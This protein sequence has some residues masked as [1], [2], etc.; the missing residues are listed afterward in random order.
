MRPSSFSFANFSRLHLTAIGLLLAAT[1]ARAAITFPV[2][3]QDPG[4]ANS[5]Y[6]DLITSHIQAAGAEWG[7]YL[8]GAGSL[9][10]QVEFTTS[11]ARVDGA[12]FTSGFSHKNGSRDVFEQGATAE[13]RTGADPNGSSPD[14]RFRINPN[15]MRSDMWFDPEP[16]VRSAAIPANKIDAM[17]LF[18][19][20]LGHSFLFTG[21]MDGTT[22][23]LPATYMSTFDEN[24]QFD[25]ANFFFVGANAEAR[26][27]GPVPVT[28][29]NYGHIGNNSPR[30]GSDLLPDL[31]NGV[32]YYYQTRYRISALDFAMLKDA[33]V[34]LLPTSKL[35]NI[36]TRLPVRSGDNALIGG[37][38][39]SGTEPKKIIVRAIGPSLGEAGV[40]GALPDPVLELYDSSGQLIAS[41]D[42]WRSDQESEIQASTIPPANDLESAIVVTLPADN[43]A[44]TA[45]VRGHGEENGIGLIEVY[46]LATGTNSQLANISSRGSVETGENVM[47]GGFIVGDAGGATVIVRGIGPSLA[48]VPNALSDPQLEVRDVNGSLLA[49][50]DNW[51]ET[52]RSQLEASGIAPGNDLESAAI[53]TIGA[54]SYTAVISGKDNKTGIAVVEVYNVQ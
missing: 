47:I 38:I 26:Y 19:H 37:F 33:G 18:I 25:D 51:K 5:A 50:N 23:A 42:N 45:I 10:V 53:L 40:S 28:Y 30:P 1:S 9:E 48:N 16:T 29:A 14:I 34:P 44:Y 22:G 12:S 35:L 20:E 43:A 41:N 32:V 24:V 54:G 2:T 27:G 21:W 7:R 8:D 15:Y 36:S 17:S 49:S 11:I 4:G 6:Y 13:L 3:F 52:Q 39:V 46:D 31:M